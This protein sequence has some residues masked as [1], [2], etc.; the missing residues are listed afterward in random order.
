MKSNYEMNGLNDGKLD[1]SM[2]FPMKWDCE[3]RRIPK[4]TPNGFL[5]LSERH[6]SMEYVKGYRSGYSN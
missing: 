6:F 1:F 2:G 3:G 4:T 5:E